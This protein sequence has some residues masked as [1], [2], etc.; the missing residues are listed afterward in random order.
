MGATDARGGFAASLY[1]LIGFC[2]DVRLARILLAV[3]AGNDPV[4]DGGMVI[5]LKGMDDHFLVRLVRFN[6]D[7][8]LFE[9]LLYPTN[10]RLCK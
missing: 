3:Y 8:F 10:H 4:S 1:R 9:L 5:P 6:D 7:R 2:E